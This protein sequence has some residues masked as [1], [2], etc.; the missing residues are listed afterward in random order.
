MDGLEPPTGNVQ[1]VRVGGT[2]TLYR[3]YNGNATFQWSPDHVFRD[4][5]NASPSITALVNLSLF[6]PFVYWSD[7]AL[8]YLPPPLAQELT[9]GNATMVGK[10]RK[11]I[12]CDLKLETLASTIPRST[13]VWELNGSMS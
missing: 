11:E 6:V 13:R 9:L 12:K 2:L 5:I 8:D 4:G 7:P 10:W 3:V 1:C